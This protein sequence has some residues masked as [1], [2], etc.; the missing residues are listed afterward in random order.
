M[1]DKNGKCAS[2][3]Y[4]SDCHFQSSDDHDPVWYPSREASDE[5]QPLSCPRMR[6]GTED[7]KSKTN[8]YFGTRGLSILMRRRKTRRHVE[9]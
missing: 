4:T 9:S 3:Q 1:I 8:K 2:W 5:A 6:E 7:E